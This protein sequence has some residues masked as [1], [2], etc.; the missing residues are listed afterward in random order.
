MGV[1]L[2]EEVG[3]VNEDEDN[4]STAAELEEI[5]CFKTAIDSTVQPFVLSETSGAVT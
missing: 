3:N 4:R 5:R 2:E 1:K